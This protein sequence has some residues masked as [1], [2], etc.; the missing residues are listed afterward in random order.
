LKQ[1]KQQITLWLLG[2]ITM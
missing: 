1:H 2:S